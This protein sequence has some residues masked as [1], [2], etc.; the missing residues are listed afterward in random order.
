V[1]VLLVLLWVLWLLMVLSHVLLLPFRL[2]L[3]LKN[4]VLVLP[5]MM[6]T[7]EAEEEAEGEVLARY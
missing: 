4:F 7:K 3:L 5:Q 1:Q 6:R 2:F